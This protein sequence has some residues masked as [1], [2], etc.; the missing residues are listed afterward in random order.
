VAFR[1]A[2]S[3][4]ACGCRCSPH[5]AGRMRGRIVIGVALGLEEFVV[6]VE[7]DPFG[8]RM[9]LRS[10]HLGRYVLVD[11]P[12]AIRELDRAW[13]RGGHVTIDRRSLPAHWLTSYDTMA[14]VHRA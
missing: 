10:R 1:S 4:L 9:F 14:R 7:P 8:R 11:D 3:F 5:G 13:A 2:P 12:D 6:G